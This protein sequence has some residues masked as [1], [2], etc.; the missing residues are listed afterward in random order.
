MDY[1]IVD[2]ICKRKYEY[3]I[4]GVA[5]DEFVWMLPLWIRYLQGSRNVI[6]FVLDVICVDRQ[7]WI[8]HV[9]IGM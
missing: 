7:L 2:M 8:G 3:D 1:T 6:A 9:E 5:V 4:I